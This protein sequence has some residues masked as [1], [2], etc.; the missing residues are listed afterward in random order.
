M[1]ELHGD[2]T[3]GSETFWDSEFFASAGELS[4]VSAAT[5]PN[6]IAMT[7]RMSGPPSNDDEFQN[8]N[9]VDFCRCDFR[10]EFCLIFG[11]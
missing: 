2:A 8:R 5:A 1:Y 9:V 4:I 3:A 6:G 7:I 10:E 11:K